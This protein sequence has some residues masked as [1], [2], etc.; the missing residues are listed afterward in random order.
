MAGLEH[1]QQ[2]A[3]FGRE[4]SVVAGVQFAHLHCPLHSLAIS[5]ST[6]SRPSHSCVR[7]CLLT[8][9]FSLPSN[10]TLKRPPQISMPPESPRELIPVSPTAR[11]ADDPVQCGFNELWAAALS[12]YRVQ[13]GRELHEVKFAERVLFPSTTADEIIEI[14][15]EQSNSF[16][17]FRANG[18]NILNRLTM[19]VRFVLQFINTTAEATS[20][21]TGPCISHQ[22]HY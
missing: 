11:S 21:R 17:S 10:I 13:T 22:G 7:A 2:Q 8:L 1:G 12:H 9:A 5:S 16:R 18:K 15:K 20:V 6:C 3:I 14:F 4:L 19:I